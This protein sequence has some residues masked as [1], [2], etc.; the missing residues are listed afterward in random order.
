LAWAEG[1]VLP[2]KPR[3]PSR[4]TKPT[5]RVDAPGR[6]P[7]KALPP[8]KSRRK[9]PRGAEPLVS[10]QAPVEELLRLLPVRVGHGWDLHRL[11]PLAPA[12]Q[13]RPMV[14]GGVR[15]IDAQ[16]SRG[17]VARSDGDVLLHAVTDAVLGALALPDIGTLFPDTDVA[18]EARDSAQ[19]LKH[20]MVLA[21]KHGYLVGNLDATVVCERP[22]IGPIK[23]QVRLNL[24]RLLGVSP[25][26]VNVKGKTHEKVDA[27]GEGRAIEAHAVIT[28][29]LIEA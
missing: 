24:A 25:E 20:A 19:F 23:E 9:S 14:L 3:I 17:P 21:R 12:G 15:I 10:P 11:E 18:N 7:P 1:D 13:G 28:M 22:K 27:I 16:L 29:L 4:T 2:R 8:P 26:R 5:R 6:T